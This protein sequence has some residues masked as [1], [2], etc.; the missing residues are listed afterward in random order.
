LTKKS[1][2]LYP[3]CLAFHPGGGMTYKHLKSEIFTLNMAE[4][5]A[6]STHFSRKP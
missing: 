3:C 4:F 2:L 6:L 1:R 5:P